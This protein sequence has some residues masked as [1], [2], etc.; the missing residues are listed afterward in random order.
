MFKNIVTVFVPSWACEASSNLDER[1]FHKPIPWAIEKYT[2]ILVWVEIAREIY[3]I[4]QTMEKTKIVK[5]E[6]FSQ[7]I[8][9]FSIAGLF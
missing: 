6:R 7:L 1:I 4:A 2:K 9:K 8:V 3:K 5:K